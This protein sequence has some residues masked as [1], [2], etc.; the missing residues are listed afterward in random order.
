M[1]EIVPRIVKQIAME[2]PPVAGTCTELLYRLRVLVILALSAVE[3][4]G[5]AGLP[6]F[7]EHR[8]QARIV[9]LS[10]LHEIGRVAKEIGRMEIAF[11][12]RM[13][14]I[15]RLALAAEWYLNDSKAAWLAFLMHLR[16]N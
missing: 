12:R 2:V 16:G 4:T 13:G 6:F 15:M 7:L 9:A 10:A 14:K 5:S 11:R 8:E 3:P 1:H